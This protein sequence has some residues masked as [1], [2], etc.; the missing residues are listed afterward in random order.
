MDCREIKIINFLLVT[1]SV[2]VEEDSQKTQSSPYLNKLDALSERKT[3]K[4]SCHL[5]FCFGRLF[6]VK[7]VVCMF[8]M[9]TVYT[10]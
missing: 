5:Y 7:H 2:L 6:Y 10:F 9:G 4:E 1:L 8:F 3:T